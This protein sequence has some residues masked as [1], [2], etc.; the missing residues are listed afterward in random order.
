[1][2]C[3][4]C[5][6]NTFD[7]NDSQECICTQCGCIQDQNNTHAEVEFQNNQYNR[8]ETYENKTQ[9]LIFEYI[10]CLKTTWPYHHIVNIQRIIQKELEATTEK[11]MASIIVA[12]VLKYASQN[13]IPCN[14]KEHQK[15]MKLSTKTLGKT[16]KH[17]DVGVIS[18]GLC[19]ESVRT[20]VAKHG[21]TGT[22]RPISLNGT[23]GHSST[24]SVA[25]ITKSSTLKRNYETL[26]SSFLHSL[27]ITYF[28]GT[29]PH[30]HIEI[31]ISLVYSALSK[32]ILYSKEGE[33]MTSLVAL[34]LVLRY[35]G[36]ISKYHELCLKTRL[37]SVPTFTKIMK[38][39]NPENFVFNILNIG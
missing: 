3:K 32:T 30:K 4:S 12:T 35:Y 9:T 7:Y 27:V 39:Y 8:C 11:N 10:K 18:E 31:K 2:Q 25:D 17:L 21:D 1:M 14:I 28:N 13:N 22:V 5:Q 33:I 19:N 6:N 29:L 37:T 26:H 24:R 23:R 15:K 36:I 20:F 16:M 34:F 38:K